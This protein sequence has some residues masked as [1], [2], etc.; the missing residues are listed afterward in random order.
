MPSL[1]SGPGY[2]MTDLVYYAGLFGGVI[3][4]YLATKNVPLHPILRLGAGLVV[5]VG[6]GWALER[7]YR[8]SRGGTPPDEFR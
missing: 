1:G 2:T 6:V 3:V 5:G 7:A 4:V 8:Q